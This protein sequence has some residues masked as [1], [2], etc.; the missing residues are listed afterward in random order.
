V[1]ASEITGEGGVVYIIP[2]A[3]ELGVTAEG[4]NLWNDHASLVFYNL[5]V[6]RPISR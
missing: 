2:L 6:S 5:G 4:I 1:T 3:L